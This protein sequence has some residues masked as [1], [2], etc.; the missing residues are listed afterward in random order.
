M[1]FVAIRRDWQL[2]LFL[3]KLSKVP[4]NIIISEN[5]RTRAENKIRFK[6]PRSKL[7]LVKKSPL[8]RGYIMWNSLDINTQKIES[9]AS[10]KNA[11]EK[12]DFT[13][14][15]LRHGLLA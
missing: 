6:L 12:I 15:K 10:F 8:C 5:P 13:N 11:I 1:L 14:I 7:H 3:H 4:E 2:L 9:R